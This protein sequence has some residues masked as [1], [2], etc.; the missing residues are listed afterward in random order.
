MSSLLSNRARIR[1]VDSQRRSALHWAVV[2]RREALLNV[3]LGQCTEKRTLVDSYDNDGRTL[4]HM[5]VDTGFEAGVQ[6]LLQ[7]GA[8]V[9]YRARKP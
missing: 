1:N 7:F 3:L 8:N 6:M 2:H 4:L 5:A 9:Y